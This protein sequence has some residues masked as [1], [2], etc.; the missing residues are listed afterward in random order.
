V[1]LCADY[2]KNPDLKETIQTVAEMGARS[3]LIP[4]FT[5]P[6]V[7]R[8]VLEYYRPDI[9]HFCEMLPDRIHHPADLERIFL[10]QQHIKEAFPETAVM[11]TLPIPQA[12]LSGG[13]SVLELARLFEP[14]SDYFLT[15]TLMGPK[16]LP[17][18]GQVYGPQQPVSGFI[19]IT[20]AVCDWDLAGDLVAA[21]GI[22]VILAGGIT[23]DNVA[24]GI[25]RV[26]P[27]GVDSCTGTNACDG[28][29]RPIR[30]Q[31]DMN[32]V[33]RLVSAAR[34]AATT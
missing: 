24:E 33:K 6:N 4:L 23:P 21:S 16:G 31:K 32:K 29:G 20:G 19:G 10:C 2:W 3:S 11:R 13:A 28:Q 27:A 30:F 15:D 7:I 18:P 12:P 34:Q 8:R 1:L 25:R 26:H 9:V 22:P 17:A 14:V 5:D